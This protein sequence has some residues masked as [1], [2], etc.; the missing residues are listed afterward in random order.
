MIIYSMVP[1]SFQI[2]VIQGI[3]LLMNTNQKAYD[4]KKD[5]VLIDTVS[6]II[7]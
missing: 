3:K 4:S 2:L 6:L 5:P 7:S 1:L